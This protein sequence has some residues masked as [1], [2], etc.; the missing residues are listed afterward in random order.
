MTTEPQSLNQRLQK[1]VS[2]STSDVVL[3]GVRHALRE[4]PRMANGSQFAFADNPPLHALSIWRAVW[5]AW[6]F[7]ALEEIGNEKQITENIIHHASQQTDAAEKQTKA[8]RTR[9]TVNAAR[10]AIRIADFIARGSTS[11][12]FSELSNALDPQSVDFSLAKT[13]D[14]LIYEPIAFPEGEPPP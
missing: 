14:H 11:S 12:A 2:K 10:H 8:L 6:C 5:L 1:I 13:G 9:Q 7:T 3:L 4:L